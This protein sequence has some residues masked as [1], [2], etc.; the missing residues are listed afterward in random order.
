MI[1][2]IAIFALKK[3]NIDEAIKLA[4]ELVDETRK[5]KGCEQYDLLQSAVD[6][7]KLVIIEG[8]ATQEALDTHSSSEHFS[9]LVP[10]LAGLCTEPP[11]VTTYAQLL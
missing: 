5:E 10:R 8:W 7:K 6:T 3:E 9:R 1:R 4:T 2:A 11:A